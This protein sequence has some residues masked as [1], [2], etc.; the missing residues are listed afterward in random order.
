MTAV[1]DPGGASLTAVA[2]E[3]I[4]PLSGAVR[5]EPLPWG[6]GATFEI[7]E[8]TRQPLLLVR[9]AR[10]LAD[11][12]LSVT[13]T[14]D[15]AE[16]PA[17]EF[18]PWSERGSQVVA[19]VPA[20]DASGTAAAFSGSVAA[21][22]IGAD[23]ASAPL[24]EAG[25]ESALALDL[26]QGVLGRLAAVVL[27]EKQRLRRQARELRAMRALQYARADALDRIGADLG[28]PR[29]SDALS[30]DATT[31]QI[32]TAPLP[33]GRE[34]DAAYRA[35][36]RMLRGVRLPTPAWIDS[37][38]NGPG[39]PADPG[40]G[41][42]A[43]R[44]L[45]ARLAVDETPN[46]L[47]VAFRLLAAER[48]KGRLELLD[49]IRR[50]HLVWPA[51]SAAG[52]A[53]H[54]GRMLPSTDTRVQDARAALAALNAPAGQ[55]VAAAVAFALRRLA[56]LQDRLGVHPFTTVLAGQHDDGGSRYELGLGAQLAG[57]SPAD[58]EAAVA[59][60][61][62]LGDQAIIPVAA[63]DD[64]AGAWLLRS[65]GFRTAEPLAD[66]SVYVSALT[67]GGLVV[68]VVPAPDA[69]VP[70]TLSA[71]L[72]APN[73]VTHDE[74][75]HGVVAT[76]AADGLAP[77]TV[78]AQ[79]LAGI[80]PTANDAALDAALTALDLP[81]VT[82]VAD[83]Q[84]RMAAVTE[85]DYVVLD[86]G[87][88][89]TGE[90]TGDPS[91]LAAL[92]S[93]AARGG[94]SSALP[95][96]TAAGTLALVLGVVDLPLAGNNLAATHTIAYR[97]QVRGL[98]GHPAGVSPRR[99]PTVTVATPGDGISVVACLAYVRTGGNDPYQWR[100]TLPDDALLSLAQY[101]HLM[102]AVE[103]ATPLGVRADTWAIRRRHVD[104]DGSGTPTP[105]SPSAARTYH[106][107]RPMHS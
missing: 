80:Q 40:A 70:L 93:H 83:V 61:Q 46:P 89:M 59:A 87:P 86:L 19:F 88:A 26:V 38:V 99:G 101:E 30:W 63:A 6:A 9:L 27:S 105:L 45:A 78:P 3:L 35:R 107:Y 102:N 56:Q 42:L 8:A 62:G 4:G 57:P 74:P 100:P 21:V 29:L 11:E 49:A 97:W 85:R 7:G 24:D 67:S 66:G 52:D 53:A 54:A 91:K 41:W 10:D 68:D 25:I 104:V 18:A 12:T 60:A 14:A 51:G 71:R 79:L 69:A 77:E 32:A 92:L 96:L 73:D 13:V 22:H 106:R 72:E 84:A 58:V 34:D 81:R 90:M 37:A 94:A 2:D 64:P 31:K 28:A 20:V 65:C 75:L 95:V 15:G 39:A 16:Q 82:S 47:L 55:P 76:L 36:L 98:T 5:P 48:S 103:V 44:G 43:D 17:L 50:T 33:D 1:T 23:G